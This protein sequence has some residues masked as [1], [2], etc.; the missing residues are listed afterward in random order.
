M[1]NFMDTDSFIVHVKSKDINK[2]IVKI[3]I[4]M[5]KQDLTPQIMN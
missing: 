3:L 4:K 5:L 1:Q 2:D